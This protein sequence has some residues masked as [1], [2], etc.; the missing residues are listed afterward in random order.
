MKLYFMKQSVI[1]DLKAN[2]KTLHPNYFKYSTNEWIYDRYDFE[3]FEFFMEIPDFEL[4]PIENHSAGEVELQN[5]K[6]LYENLKR[7]SESQASDERLWAGLCNGVF[8]EYVRKRWKYPTTPLKNPES[9]ASAIISRFFF[10]GGGRGGMFRNT[11]SKCWWVG[12]STY[13]A[14]QSNR[15]LMLD[16]IGPEDFATKVSDI[17]YS[18]TFA[19]N[20]DIMRG[21]CK[22]L[23]FYRDKGIS[24]Q[25]KENIRPTMQYLNALGGSVL[26]DMFTEEEITRE[27]VNS[28]E[29]VRKGV[30]D[31]FITEELV[32]D[33][34]D[35]V[36][37]IA[38]DDS[39]ATEINIDYQTDLDSTIA[40]TTE[41]DD[42]EFFGNPETVMF[43]CDV[44]LYDMSNNK[45]TIPFIPKSEGE[46]AV[47]P[48]TKAIMGHRAGDVVSCSG[49]DYK[50]LSIE[51]AE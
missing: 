30:D 48:L 5:C 42:K 37:D 51:W 12:E 19:A 16:S 17:F 14:E 23:K 31:T 34:E 7:I 2:M 27:V 18:N 10:S 13:T 11:L 3:P 9:D 28:I 49:K 32:R 46:D 6:I 4:Y 44:V 39:N 50:I 38:I 41:I 8:Y 21:I 29:R 1:D 20:P 25:V 35:N 24:L 15:W 36:I 22:G 40:R 47:Y 45:K 33:P 43:G 26:L